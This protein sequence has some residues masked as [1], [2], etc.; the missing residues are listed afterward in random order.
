MIE[1]ILMC[2]CGCKDFV[3][4]REDQYSAVKFMCPKCEYVASGKDFEHTRQVWNLHQTPVVY[5]DNV[6]VAEMLEHYYKVHET[7]NRVKNSVQ[8]FLSYHNITKMC[9]LQ[10]KYNVQGI[11]GLHDVPGCGEKVINLFLDLL[12]HYEDKRYTWE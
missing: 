3:V 10:N 6:T 9:E 8:D 2:K 12:S 5:K 11:F 1:G 7:N 4:S